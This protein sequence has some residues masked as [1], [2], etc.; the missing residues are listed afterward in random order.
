MTRNVWRKGG[1]FMEKSWD[2]HADSKANKDIPWWT[3]KEGN[4]WWWQDRMK[5]PEEPKIENA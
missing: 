1:T 4:W 5:K 2:N 3:N